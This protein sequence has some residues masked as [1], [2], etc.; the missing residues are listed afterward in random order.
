MEDADDII[1][2]TEK[3]CYRTC[4]G[5]SPPLLEYF[6]VFFPFYIEYYAL[7]DR[8]HSHGISSKL[9][10]PLILLT[11]GRRGDVTWDEMKAAMLR[12]MEVVPNDWIACHLYLSWRSVA[13]VMFPESDLDIRPIDAILS[14]I[15]ENIDL[16]FFKSHLL[17]LEGENLRRNFKR[18]EAIAK[19][20]QAL[21]IARKFDDQVMI[22][23]LLGELAN[24]TKHFDLEEGLQL[25][26][27]SKELSEQI[28]YSNRIGR[29]QH[30][31]GHVM[32][33]RGELDAAIKG[34]VEYKL[35]RESL[36]LT[37][38]WIDAVIAFYYNQVG[39][40]ER[41]YEL[42]K[43]VFDLGS[44]VIRHFSYLRLQ[45]TWALI[46]LGRFDEAKVELAASQA[47][48]RRTGDSRELMWSKLVEGVLDKVEKRFD[49]S[50]QCFHD[51]LKIVEELPAPVVQN[52]CYINLVEIE[53]E[54]LT[55]ESLDEK[56]ET[57][58]Y[59][60]QKLLEHAE[61]K[62]LPGV[63]ARALLL[64]AELRRKQKLF[65]E[66]RKILKE[67]QEIAKTPSMNYLN[68]LALSKFPE[69][70]IA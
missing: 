28:G 61:K 11:E 59:W 40:G 49:S 46:N 44:S 53:T 67:V 10:H 47:I 41:A 13:E 19:L 8:L 58:G 32:G 52:I 29:V 54:M 70:I 64:K 9:G 30:Q 42:A 20:K 38:Y 23:D 5:R 2:F 22:A 68:D 27:S 33:I 55:D 57:S 24:N 62:N 69:F 26:A 6:A 45:L 16:A 48:A 34:Q 31:L 37:T 4:E 7:V 18:V 63:A 56:S 43:A 25:F 51:V 66:V 1:D 35:I 36:G 39:D 17:R 12:A 60:M 65:D 50:I 21:S 15:D 3:L 14:T